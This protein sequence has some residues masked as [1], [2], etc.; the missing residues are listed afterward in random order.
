MNY[1]QSASA[2]P[3]VSQT[4]TAREAMLFRKACMRRSHAVGWPT[5]PVVSFPNLGRLHKYPK[6]GSLVSWSGSLHANR[7]QP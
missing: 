7:R 5:C 3:L 2:E 6:I 4:V 1:K